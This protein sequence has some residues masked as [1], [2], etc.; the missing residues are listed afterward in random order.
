MYREIKKKLII[1]NNRKPFPEETAQ[2][3]GEMCQIDW[4]ASCLRLS[5]I[6]VSRE[7]VDKILRG[8]LLVNISL[9]THQLVHRYVEL[10]RHIQSMQEMET[11]L[12]PETLLEIYEFLLEP[13]PDFEP[14]QGKSYYRRNNPVLFEWHY[15]PPHF[16]EIQEQMELAFHWLDCV[17]QQ[18]DPDMN[19]FRRAAIL[20]NKIVEI[21]PFGDSTA[22]IA[23]AAVLYELMAAGYPPIR[24]SV[25]EQEYNRAIELYL[26]KD[27]S[28][29]L[30][31]AIERG[32]FDQ[33]ELMVRLTAIR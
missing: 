18:V 12:S 24:L 23:R 11:E 17:K 21:Y 22:T 8:E 31:D 27:E 6:P 19:P 25:S 30:A 1:L 15:N 3:I 10:I 2:Y 32:V 26:K 5:G 29:L 7:D 4:I 13:Q 14:E 28:G 33:L 20:H 16:N 9:K